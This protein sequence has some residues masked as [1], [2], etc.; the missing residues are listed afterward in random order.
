MQIQYFSDTDTLLMEF[1]KSSEVPIDNTIDVG[2]NAT[3]DLDKDGH[4][5]ALTLEHVAVSWPRKNRKGWPVKRADKEDTGAM[6]HSDFHIGLEFFC[7]GKRWRCTDVGTRVITA[8]SLEP[9][10]I[11]SSSPGKA[12]TSYISNDPADLNGPPYF[13]A[14][15]I[16]DEYDIDGCS[17][18]PDDLE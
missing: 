2:P 6:K 13:V 1:R 17:L 5:L 18:D 16:F 3:A 15:S 8:I 4:I 12:P 11:M 10:T 7:G 14:E 9:R